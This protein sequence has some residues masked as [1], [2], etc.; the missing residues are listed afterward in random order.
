M[1]K[2]TKR[3][4]AIM[5]AM[6]VIAMSMFTGVVVSATS[7]GTVDLLEFGD[8]LLEAGS[9]SK[10]Y[11][12]VL[13]DNG[14]TGDSWENA[15]IIDSAEEFVYLCKAS[16]DDTI[17]KYY[18]VADGIKGFDL[19]KGDIDIDGT[20]AENIDKIKAGGKNHSGGT[21]GFQ[22]SFDGNGATVYGAWTNHTEGN[23]SNYA[24]LF[25]CTKG[26]VTIKNIN[27]KMA[28]FT[29]KNLIGGIVGYHNK[30]GANEV[31][32]LTIENCSV[33]DSH[34]ELVSTGGWMHGVGAIVGGSDNCYSWKEADKGVDGNNDGDMA[35]TIYVNG[36]VN[37]NNCYVNLEEEHVISPFEQDTQ[38]DATLRG[39]HAGVAGSMNTNALSVRDCVVIG[40][41]PYGTT[42]CT[43]FNDIQHSGLTS[44][45]ANIYTTE[46]VA[47]TEVVI[48]GNGAVAAPQNFTGKVYPLADDQLKGE[49]ALSSMNLDWG[50]WMADDE[51]YPELRSM[52]KDVTY[53]DNGNGTH[54]ESCACGFGGVASKHIW[55][56]GACACGAILD[57]DSR[58]TIYWDGSIATG[59]ATGTG[60]E[61]DPYVINTA[62]EFAWLVKNAKIE[63][64]QGKYFEI[65]ENIGEI[66]L[67]DKEFAQDILSLENADAVATFFEN[68]DYV[69]TGWPH[70]GWEAGCFCGIFDGNGATVY[71]LYQVSENNAG[72]FSNVDAGAVIKNIG[73]KNSYL[74]STAG[75]YQVGGIAAVT[76]G[77]TYQLKTNGAIWFDSCVVANNYIYNSSTSHD[78]TGVIIGASSDMVYIENCLVYGN[79]ATYG[80]GVQAAIWSSSQNSQIV[81]GDEIIPEGLV[82]KDDGADTPRYY[83]VVR[84]SII[85]GAKPYDLAQQVG[86]RFNDPKCYEYSYTDADIANDVFS[87]GVTL[88]VAEDQLKQITLGELATLQLGEGWLNTATY[89]ELAV[90]HDSDLEVSANSNGTHSSVCSCGVEFIAPCTFVDGKCTL[91]EAALTCAS[92]RTIYWNGGV[93]TGFADTSAGTKDDPIIIGSAEE[94]AYLITCKADVTEGK[95]FEIAEDIGTIVLQPQEFA[96]DIMALESAAEVQ[97]FFENTDI[98]FAEWPEKSWEASCFAG[99]FNG[100]GVKI[101]GLYIVSETNAGLFST[102][103][104]GAAIQ[105][106]AVLNSYMISNST[107]ANYQVGAI[108]AV[109]SNGTY[110][111]GAGGVIWLN[112]CTVGNCFMRNDG[113]DPQ[114][115]GV[116]FG[117]ASSDTVVIDNCM[118]Y[119]NDAR[120]SVTPGDYSLAMPLINL[121]NNSIIAPAITPEGLD[122]KVQENANQNGDS[123]YYSSVRNTIAFG[124]DLMNTGIARSYRRNDP[125]TFEN[126]YTD[127]AYGTV[128]FSDGAE[129]TYEDSQIKYVTLDDLNDNDLGSAWAKTDS[130]PELISAH[131]ATYVDNGDGTHSASCAC[132]VISGAA[133]AHTYENGECI[134]GAEDTTSVMYGDANGDGKVNGRDYAMILQ[135]I[136]GVNVTIDLTAADVTG[137]GKVNGRDY[138]K[139]LQA[140]NGWDVNLDPRG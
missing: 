131:V 120:H 94:L 8:Y 97:S 47:I 135:Y 60:T 11:D 43:S 136:N 18:K 112:G 33:V 61:D 59:I 69:F 91:C 118:V 84:N 93:S 23:V 126:C 67:Q 127:A 54:N 9:A 19:T 17:G 134:C 78:R 39:V 44:H 49:A 74:T 125:A 107:S 70:Q 98:A 110:G 1:I 77:I 115:S 63:N 109:A 14:E 2:N 137:D 51:G 92:K 31:G 101:Y 36:A 72:L 55:V 132:G 121:S 88:K 68:E 76:N 21:P 32:T 119:G 27:V 133:E 6:A 25:S 16:G 100:N 10:W 106:V 122:A 57:C 29:A 108:A 80:D 3:V 5:L 35:D 64:T 53:V 79:N 87:N 28:V 66:V 40:I 22:G 58:D 12:T 50:V 140:I 128:L 102:V 65:A 113:S 96:T 111:I 138:A 103:D 86:S 20:L 71:G 62:A 99:Q 52:H 42:S 139:I 46:D 95:Y 56:D 85:L 26:N 45:F 90:F 124:T 37:I 41:K 73:L 82:V 81:T 48:G 30:V 116:L 7:E 24:G 4:L 89:P 130:Y 13:A 83:N 75:N 34:F 129:W 38:T 105:N 104:A 123:I 15:I 114:R 117:A